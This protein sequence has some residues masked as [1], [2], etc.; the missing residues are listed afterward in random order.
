MFSHAEVSKLH[1]PRSINKE[2]STFDIP[3]NIT[4]KKET[5]FNI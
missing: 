3:V 4:E 1:N 2:I 5:N